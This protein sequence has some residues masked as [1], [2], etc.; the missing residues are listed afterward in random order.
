VGAARSLRARYTLRALADLAQILDYI[1]ARSPQGGQKV[2]AR[3]QD[4]INLA[5][6]H[7]HAGVR[8][9]RKGYRC[10][11]AHPYPYLIFYEP[12]DEEI[13]IHAV[14]HAARRGARAP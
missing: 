9:R 14:R 3:I 6:R 10:L 1:S 2:K 5:L 13:V 4:M 7:P 11:V 12:R 8:T